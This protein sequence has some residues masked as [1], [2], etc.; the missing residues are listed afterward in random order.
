M[1]RMQ[2]KPGECVIRHATTQT[3]DVKNIPICDENFDPAIIAMM[4][5]MTRTHIKG[6]SLEAERIGRMVRFTVVRRPSG[7]HIRLTENTA[8]WNNGV[9]ELTTTIVWPMEDDEAG[10]MADLEQCAALMFC[11]KEPPTK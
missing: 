4:P 3:G 7:K 6:Y 5:E 1:K 11:G 10:M 8:I 9:L 2:A